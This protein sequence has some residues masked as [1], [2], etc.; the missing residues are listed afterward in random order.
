M[1][2]SMTSGI[3]KNAAMNEAGV[4][5]IMTEAKSCTVPFCHTVPSGC[6][7]ADQDSIN[8]TCCCFSSNNCKIAALVLSAFLSIFFTSVWPSP[9]SC[10]RHLCC[11]CRRGCYHVIC[12]LG[13]SVVSW[14]TPCVELAS[15]RW[16][17]HH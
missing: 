17:C 7:L 16:T 2:D 10:L 9:I 13:T 8:V 6:L 4:K 5:R 11:R 3:A 1:P 12:W 14:Y 15:P